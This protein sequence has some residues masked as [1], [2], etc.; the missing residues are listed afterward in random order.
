MKS[1]NTKIVKVPKNLE[2]Q[3]EIVQF[4]NSIKFD[5][6]LILY[7]GVPM[8]IVNTHPSGLQF[9][10][11]KLENPNLEKFEVINISQSF[12]LLELQDNY[13]EYLINQ[14]FK[15]SDHFVQNF[16]NEIVIKIQP[17]MYNLHKLE[18][19]ATYQISSFDIYRDTNIKKLNFADCAY[20]N[21]FGNFVFNFDFFEF[22]F[23][24]WFNLFYTKDYFERLKSRNE[25]V[26]VKLS[27]RGDRFDLYV[28]VNSNDK[29]FKTDK[30]IFLSFELTNF[31]N[32]KQTLLKNWNKIIKI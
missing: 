2:L 28:T 29:F 24:N 19:G 21:K 27:N 30:N 18:L 8:K 11:K 1:F 12:K 32:F 23:E 31:D 7:N 16:S 13:L 26:F 20:F 17:Y 15:V 10:C 14:K 3:K 4:V 22:N 25:K 9:F 6:N 5:K